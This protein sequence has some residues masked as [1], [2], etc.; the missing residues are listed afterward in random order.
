MEDFY[1]VKQVGKILKIGDARIL[2]LIRSGQL[3]AVDVSPQPGGRPRWR[4]M[5]SDLDGFILRRTYQPMPSRRK[6][7]KRRSTTK[8]YF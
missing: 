1:T 6:R 7:R 5:Q 4:I 8:E 2:T 3:I